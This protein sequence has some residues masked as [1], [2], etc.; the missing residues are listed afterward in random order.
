MSRSE[1][2]LELILR[3]DIDASTLVGG[4]GAG[5]IPV[6]TRAGASCWPSGVRRR[7]CRLRRP[8]VRSAAAASPA[9][10]PETD[11]RPAY[12]RPHPLHRIGFPGGGA[13]RGGPA[14]CGVA[15]PGASIA[16]P[17]TD[18]DFGRSFV[19]L[20]PDGHRLRVYA[21]AEDDGSAVPDQN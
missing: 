3:E 14:P 5:A 17:P 8:R 18:P 1:R 6:D 9:L 20:D 10:L 21:I 15:G 11:S 16:L 12:R 4:P 19:A 2:L 7:A 13:R